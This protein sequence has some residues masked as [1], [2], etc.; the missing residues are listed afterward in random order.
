MRHSSEKG[1]LC[2]LL[3]LEWNELK[4]CCLIK[5][6]VQDLL[7]YVFDEPGSRTRLSW[8]KKLLVSIQ[9]LK[10]SGLPSCIAIRSVVTE[11]SW[12]VSD[13][14][15]P[16]II[17]SEVYC[18]NVVKISVVWSYLLQHLLVWFGVDFFFNVI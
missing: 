8:F 10:G 4:H 2:S 11:S 1:L 12:L 9:G 3:P 7:K 15:L 16:F 5:N 6:I 13:R 14:F 17:H 18:Q